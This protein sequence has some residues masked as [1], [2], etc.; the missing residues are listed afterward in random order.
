MRQD[1]FYFCRHCGNVIGVI[2]AA[3]VPVFCC[4]EKM[5]ALEAHKEEAG[6]EKH[7]PIVSVKEEKIKV[8]VGEAAH[9]MEKEHSIQWIYLQTAKGGQMKG[10]AAGEPPEAR[11]ALV[12]DRPVAAYA[13]CNKHGLWLTEI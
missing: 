13:Y 1:R 2:H 9:P 6:G 11:F 8:A 4:G 7:K 12:E 5:E 10:L 3:G